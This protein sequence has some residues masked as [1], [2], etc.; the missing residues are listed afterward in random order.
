M[1]Y[2]EA[3]RLGITDEDLKY[4]SEIKENT[5]RISIPTDAKRE[6]K[7]V[8]DLLEAIK[9]KYEMLKEIETKKEQA[10]EKQ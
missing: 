10:I 4:I 5:F 3:L 8:H 2:N 7:V 6:T 9:L 1:S